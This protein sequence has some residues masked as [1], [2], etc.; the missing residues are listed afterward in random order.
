M[1]VLAVSATTRFREVLDPMF[2]EMGVGFEVVKNTEEAVKRLRDKERPLSVFRPLSIFDFIILDSLI[3]KGE[4]YISPE[5]VY[6]SIKDEVP[7]LPVIIVS[8]NI[9]YGQLIKLPENMVIIYVTELDFLQ[10]LAGFVRENIL[11]DRKLYFYLSA[12]QTL[13]RKRNK[14][15]LKSHDKETCD[16]A[17]DLM[18]E[19]RRGL[20]GL[21]NL[22]TLL[23]NR[24]LKKRQERVKMPA[25]RTLLWVDPGAKDYWDIYPEIKS[26]GLMFEPAITISQAKKKLRDSEF[27]VVVIE[28]MLPANIRHLQYNQVKLDG[29]KTLF[30]QLRKG[31]LGDLN[32]STP[33]VFYTGRGDL[34]ALR[35][36]RDLVEKD[37][38]EGNI[39]SS[40]VEKTDVR[41]LEKA[42]RRAIGKVKVVES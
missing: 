24:G 29:G 27:E 7:G 37:H 38:Q 11:P 22:N 8:F 14:E 23:K 41:N 18:R 35:E 26:I 31:L 21:R 32:K 1:R 36:C 4:A 2:R 25:K 20:G 9:V 30:E 42:V 39:R 10:K 12:I 6:W 16:R 33:V 13:I 17:R 3:E 34:E 19:N 28:L 5:N 40:L 15:G